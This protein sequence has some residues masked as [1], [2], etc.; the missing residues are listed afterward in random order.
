MPVDVPVL[1]VGGVSVPTIG[2]WLAAGTD[3]FGIGSNVYKAGW[4]TE[5]VSKEAKAFVAAFDAA[6]AE[7]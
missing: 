2:D 3:G 6:T 7:T 4:S 1:A 5:Q